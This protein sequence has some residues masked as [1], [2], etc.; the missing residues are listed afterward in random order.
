MC[1][2]QKKLLQ[3]W[4]QQAEMINKL[5]KIGDTLINHPTLRI[6]YHICT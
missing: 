3:L 2:C 1:E 6:P 5:I 4:D